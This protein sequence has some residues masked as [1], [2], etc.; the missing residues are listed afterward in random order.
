MNTTIKNHRFYL[1]FFPLGHMAVD[2]G[3]GAI[4]LL[5]PAIA[6]AY[7]LSA[8]QVGILLTS[9]ELG[10][11]IAYAPAG[12]LGDRI[13]RRGFL[14]L[15]SFWWVAIGFFIASFAPNY[16]SLV[17]LITVAIV[18]VAAWHP[19]A[20]GVMVEQMSDRKAQALGIHAIGG[21]I[22][23]VLAPLS[24]GFLLIYFDWREV[25][26]ISAI[27]AL[28][29][30]V[31]LIW[32]R[33]RIPDS[34][35]EKI[36][37]SDLRNIWEAWRTPLGVITALMLGTYQTSFVALQA[38]TPLFL[39]RE[40][41]FSIALT[42]VVFAGMLTGGAIL[43][44]LIGR[45]SDTIG[46]KPVAAAALF[47]A[48]IMAIVAAFATS[49]LLLVGGLIISGTLIVCV[50]SVMLASAVDVTS[51]RESTALGLAFTI[52]DGV[53]ALGAIAAGAIG[54]NDLRLAIGFAGFAAIVALVFA[55]LLPSKSLSLK[56]STV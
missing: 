14:L 55:F 24:V 18:G 30:G 6:I 28:V 47:G 32:L 46:R 39:V 35:G 19:V 13:K 11:G 40:H 1:L 54:T 37:K 3:G 50:R 52:M 27:P 17:A 41:E 15:L 25:L 23:H 34:T 8:L 42:S 48:G 45:A 53:G 44:P 5:A 22:S 2:W 20:T 38:M 9:M 16:W 21:T 36:G 49:G 51:G 43:S 10:A 31:S 29:V 26:K 7:D 33:R 56:K 12:M 4:L